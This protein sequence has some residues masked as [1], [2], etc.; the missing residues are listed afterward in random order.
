MCKWC[1]TE[2]KWIRPFNYYLKLFQH[3]VDKM[4]ELLIDV[5][6]WRRT[7]ASQTCITVQQ[8]TIWESKQNRPINY[9]L[10]LF[11]HNIDKMEELLIDVSIWRRTMTW[12]TCITTI[13]NVLLILFYVSMFA[14]LLIM[15]SHAL[16]FPSWL[17]HDAWHTHQRMER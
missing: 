11:Q 2:S 7:T 5:L 12:Q 16:F 13:H 9:Y 1:N 14:L 17:L 10:K 8:F 6:I 15:V 3:S 4:E